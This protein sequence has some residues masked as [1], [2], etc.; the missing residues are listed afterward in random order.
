MA[1]EEAAA[2]ED[3][4]I[5]L[6]EVLLLHFDFRFNR[7]SAVALIISYLFNFCYIVLFTY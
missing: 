6:E 7:K 2:V 3:M 5:T 4:A 1:E